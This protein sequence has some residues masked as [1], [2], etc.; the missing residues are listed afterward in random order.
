MK[1]KECRLLCSAVVI[2]VLLNLI[3]PQIV[4]RLA[5]ENQKTGKAKDMN[6][7]DQIISMLVHHAHT[8]LTSS[9]IVLVIV[10]IS[11]AVAQRV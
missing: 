8:P 6:F 10:A 9:I 11:V 7:W 5:N 4:L 1:S 3:L 2:A